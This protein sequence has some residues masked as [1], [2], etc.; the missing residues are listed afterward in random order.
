M[1]ILVL[2]LP[3]RHQHS[4]LPDPTDIQRTSVCLG[5]SAVCIASPSFAAFSAECLAQQVARS[6]SLS[7]KTIIVTVGTGRLASHAATSAGASN[8]LEPNI[9][10]LGLH[11]RPRLRLVSG[12]P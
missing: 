9:H 11:R 12:G 8:T 4:V 5:L 6:I 3:A 10:S 7:F 2:M 1:L